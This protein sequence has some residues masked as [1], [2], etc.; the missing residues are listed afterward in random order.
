MTRLAAGSTAPA[1]LHPGLDAA[2]SLWT[3][4]N[5]IKTLFYGIN[6]AYHE[7]E[8]RNIVRY[9]LICFAFTLSGLAA[10]LLSAALVV[11][12]PMVLG[13]FG[14]AEDSAGSPVYAGQCCSWSMSRP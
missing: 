12:V 8:K 14:L 9:N 10:V 7:V 4:N 13:L 11:G 3:A 1:D 2:L 6:V 5:G